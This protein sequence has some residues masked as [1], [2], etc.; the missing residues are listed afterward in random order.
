[1]PQVHQNQP[2][3]DKAYGS[4][5]GV[6]PAPRWHRSAYSC[7]AK[8]A[9]VSGVTVFIGIWLR[10]QRLECLNVHSRQI[11]PGH[12]MVSKSRDTTNFCPPMPLFVHPF[13]PFVC[14]VAC[15]ICLI[16]LICLFGGLIDFLYHLWLGDF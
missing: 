9:K 5:L 14:L 4:K 13:V 1:M 3:P 11:Q 2:D 10:L 7:T 12:L 16:C 8:I 6:V 15:L